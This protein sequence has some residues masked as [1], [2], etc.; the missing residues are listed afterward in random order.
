[1]DVIVANKNGVELRYL[2]FDT[3]DYEV[4]REE[5]S[6]EIVIRREEYEYIPPEARI[7]IPNTELGGL[8]RRLTTDTE[9]GTITVGGIT[10]RGMMQKKIIQPPSGQD[11]AKDSGELNAIIKAKVEAAFPDLFYGVSTS[12]GV[13]V[14]N[15]QYERY[16][17]MEAGLTKLLQSVGYKLDIKYSQANKA[18]IVQAVP[19]VDYT[20]SIEFSSDMRANYTM[21]QQGD[22]VNHL[23][24]LGKGELKNRTVYHLYI[25]EDGNVSTTQY[26]TGV[27]EI[28]A[29][30]DAGGSEL[31]DL[32]ENGTTEIKELANNDTF[33]IKVDP[34]IDVAIGD[35]VGG[36]DYLS[37]MTMSAPVWSKIIRYSAGITD[38][39]YTLE[40]DR[41]TVEEN[42]SVS[43]SIDLKT[44]IQP[45]EIKTDIEPLT[46]LELSKEQLTKD[47]S[48]V[49]DNE[50]SNRL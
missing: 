50:Y 35:I 29:I 19:I 15:F 10:W 30:Y 5:N 4:G 9:H 12:T 22:G 23:I 42:R 33:E 21:R 18:V 25:D 26:Y 47:N 6:F 1:M 41:M 43:Q 11:Y 44:E 27:D 24:C 36:R 46:E 49:V 20:N 38:I 40:N 37:K 7:Y 39:E 45:V 34:S 32:I 13:T 2:V 28:A 16:C 14:S 8:F 31:P 48:E 17:T 3:Y